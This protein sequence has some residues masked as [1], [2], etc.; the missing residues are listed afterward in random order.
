[1][2]IDKD[3]LFMEISK[4][5]E[6]ILSSSCQ[7]QRF[8]INTQGS[9]YVVG[10]I[11]GCFT[12]LEQVL[13]VID[14]NKKRDRLFC[15]GDLVDRGP[16]SFKAMEYLSYDWFYSVKG[17][18][19]HFVVRAAMKDSSFSLERWYSSLSGGSWWND[20]TNHEKELIGCRFAELPTV[21]E[22]ETKQGLVGFVHAHVPFNVTWQEFI[23]DVENKNE[24]I[25]HDAAVI[26]YRARQYS[27]VIEGIDKVY[28]GHVVFND[29]KLE[30]NSVFMDTGSGYQ[31]Y[32]KG[33]RY[34]KPNGKLTVIKI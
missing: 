10:D 28:F 33:T 23:K 14:F 19:D 13:T 4:K 2:I 27:P 31:Y 32:K 16:E 18:H 6:S 25:L 24:K 21:I 30:N 20:L 1:M 26:R 7:V 22:L 34:Y 8:G 5:I 29:V 12:E 9:D 17:N 3:I 15:C 11:H